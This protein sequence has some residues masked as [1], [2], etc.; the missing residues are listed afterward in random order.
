MWKSSLTIVAAVGIAALTSGAL[1]QSEDEAE[2]KITSEIHPFIEI[3][4]VDSALNWSAPNFSST[5]NDLMANTTPGTG[6]ARFSVQANTDYSLTVTT[7][8]GCWQASN[9][10]ASDEASFRQV[11]F[12]H[13]ENGDWIGGRLFLDRYP[14]SPGLT[15]DWNNGGG[16]CRI[17]TGA[18]AAETHTWGLGASFLPRLVGNEANPGGVPGKLP[19]PGRYSAT[20][21]ITAATQ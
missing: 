2:I 12:I 4:V 21:R 15:H 5:A 9:L 10:L 8:D 19:A 13:E 11:R 16:D 17:S 3:N 1:A 7:V 14:D 18:Y 6:R 20:A